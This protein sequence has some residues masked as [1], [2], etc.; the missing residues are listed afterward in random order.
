MD[1]KIV[2]VGRNVG[3]LRGHQ[4]AA[5][6]QDGLQ[7]WVPVSAADEH[8]DKLEETSKLERFIFI[9]FTKRMTVRHA[10]SRGPYWRKLGE[11]RTAFRQEATADRHWN[12]RLS[13]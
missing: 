4:R 8:R 2:R 13:E 3:S 1:V 5:L 7:L 12:L 6:V 9:L 10:G 11:R